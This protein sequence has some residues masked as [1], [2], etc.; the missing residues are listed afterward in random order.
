MYNNLLGEISYVEKTY[1]EY[2][3]L[4]NYYA[5]SN[6]QSIFC[7]YFNIDIANSTY[8]KGDEASFDRYNSGVRYNIYDYTPLFYLAAITNDVADQQDL[9]GQM[10]QG[11]SNIIVYTIETPR[12]EDIVVFPY[13]PLTG[14]EIFRVSNVRAAINAKASTPAVNWYELTIEYA[15]LADVKK[16]NVI[17]QYT[18]NL[19]A[20]KYMLQGEFISMVT[21]LDLMEK[22]FKTLQPYFDEE[23]ELYTFV[24]SDG[25]ILAPL[26]ANK[27][28]L[29]FLA[30][31]G[32]NE[33]LHSSPL[34]PF[35]VKKYCCDNY[36]DSNK[37]VFIGIKHGCH[38]DESMFINGKCNPDCSFQG[39]ILYP[40]DLIDY[41]YSWRDVVELEYDTIAR[42]Y[43]QVNGGNQ[44]NYRTLNYLF[45][46]N[47]FDLVLLI[48]TWKYYVENDNFPVEGET[49]YGNG[50]YLHEDQ[51]RLVY[52]IR[53]PY[54][55]HKM[56]TSSDYV[57]GDG[58]EGGTS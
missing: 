17:N 38:V 30:H 24:L 11:T 8:V 14:N 39:E 21:Y 33:S 40:G 5:N 46:I 23:Y 54:E 12:V 55:I 4:V 36:E 22:H 37:C 1:E 7:R 18:Y 20:Q 3:S 10:F 2:L 16:L 29:D 35:G 53:Q 51:E 52:R 58:S 26:C 31:T 25:T 49:S 43:I 19:S 9:I 41:E 57:E 42:K 56:T 28:I 13:A 48:N 47:V 44:T 6:R 15:P 32:S 50:L 34:R 27:A 45:D